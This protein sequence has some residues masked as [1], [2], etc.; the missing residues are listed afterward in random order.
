MQSLCSIFQ[1]YKSKAIHNWPLLL[2]AVRLVVF[3]ISK[4][5]IE[6][7]SQLEHFIY[8]IICCCVQYFK[9]TNRKQFTTFSTNGRKY[10]M[11]CSIFQR[12]KSKAIH[13]DLSNFPA[14]E[15]VVFNISKIQIESN[16]QHLTKGTASGVCCVQYFKDTNRKQFTTHLALHLQNC[17][18][19]SIFQRYKSKAIHN[20]YFAVKFS[21][22]VVF[23]I[24]KIQIESNSQHLTSC[25]IDLLC[26]VQ[27][28][29]DTNRKQFTTRNIKG[30]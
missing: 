20:I 29:K 30:N 3:N 2:M 19:C 27:Y 16:S 21:N 11:L 10:A 25:L 17:L 9:D 4:I 18:L 1:R 24:S 5:Q 15:L 14:S 7:N 26:C 13:N 12:Y 22:S 28:F 6:S 23:N 8:I